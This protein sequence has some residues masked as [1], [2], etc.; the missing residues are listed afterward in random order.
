[1]IL[2]KATSHNHAYIRRA[3]R[4]TY[5][6]HH[7]YASI[8]R[9]RPQFSASAGCTRD[10]EAVFLLLRPLHSL[11]ENVIDL[12]LDDGSVRDGMTTCARRSVEESFAI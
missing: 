5:I 4:R 11:D 12:G 9:V 10:S 1:M 7:A 6:V 8:F 3:H 2:L